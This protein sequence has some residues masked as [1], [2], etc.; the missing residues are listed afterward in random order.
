MAPL[1]DDPQRDQRIR[2][3]GMKFLTAT[4]TVLWATFLTCTAYHAILGRA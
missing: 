4:V 3:L 2:G 1:L